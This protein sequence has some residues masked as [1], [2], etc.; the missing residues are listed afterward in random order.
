MLNEIE[1]AIRAR[2]KHTDY[3]M[4]L[5]RISAGSKYRRDWVP[6]LDIHENHCHEWV[7]NMVP[8]LVDGN[9]VVAG[10][11]SGAL[12]DDHPA[13]QDLTKAVNSWAQ[14]ENLQQQLVENALDVQYDFC[15]GMVS[16]EADP[17]MD[18]GDDIYLDEDTR[19]KGSLKPR[20]YRISP[21]RFFCDQQAVNRMGR[22]YIGHIWIE[23]KAALEKRKLPSGKKMFDKRALASVTL[24]DDV[25][26]LL[27]E[28]GVDI[29]SSGFDREQVV[30]YEF[31][32]P[33]TGM[34]YTLAMTTQGSGKG[35]YLCDPRPY[36]GLKSGPYIMGGIN[37]LPDQTYP[38]P[39]LAI[40]HDLMREVNLHQ[41][42][43]SD[44]AGMAKRLLVLDADPQMIGKAQSAMNGAIL[45]IPGFKGA[46]TEV[47]TGGASP[48]QLAYIEILNSRMDKM[49]GMTDAI[50]G[51]ATGATAEEIQT[52]QQNRNLRIKWSQR[53]FRNFTA[54]ILRIVAKHFWDNPRVRQSINHEDAITGERVV[55]VYEG[56]DGQKYGIPFEDLTLTID[57]YSMAPQDDALKIRQQIEG[58][59]L[60]VSNV[61]AMKSNPQVKWKQMVG[62]FYDSIG[63]KG[64]GDRYIDWQMLQKMQVLT[65]PAAFADPAMLA[66]SMG[67]GGQGVAGTE[68]Q[69]VEP[70]PTSQPSE[71]RNR[72]AERGAALRYAG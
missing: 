67:Q 54:G 10:I 62:D 1:D 40:I 18:G 11:K 21:R 22:R 8:N 26:K 9:P 37:M 35:L 48:D 38:L 12:E 46:A 36:R 45:G 41:G 58:M 63:Q 34:I 52:V 15:V 72:A 43:I 32:V 68:G 27:A 71:V 6:P 33:E 56:G 39:P 55:G 42:Q 16:L 3:S 50:K 30:G 25:R 64:R 24:D 28:M 47:K 60:I 53:C 69:G 14:S 70:T 5:I 51:N 66:Q 23:D 31:Y 19:R 65:V 44:D 57:P 4:D 59:N 17:L 29:G 2:R 13:L 61:E 7:S 20:S 49:L